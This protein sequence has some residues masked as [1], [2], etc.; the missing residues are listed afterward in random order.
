[1]ITREQIEREIQITMERG[2]MT[3]ECVRDLAMMLYVLEH[4]E[5]SGKKEK[6]RKLSREDAEEWVEDMGETFTM[7]ETMH[8]LKDRHG[9][10]DPV[11]FWVIVNAMRSDYSGVAHK[12]GMDHLGFYADMA[13]AWLMDEDAKPGK[14]VR[15]WDYI[16][17]HE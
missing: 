14:A 6:H 8:A 15:Y 13:M 4:M 2:C 11:E 12:Y 7:E 5:G 3:S 16:V 10:C 17:E 1:M 9:S